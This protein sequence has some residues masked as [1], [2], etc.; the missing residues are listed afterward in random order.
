VTVPAKTTEITAITVTPTQ[1][2]LESTTNIKATITNNG[3]KIN[4]ARLK[5]K[6]AGPDRDFS[7]IMRTIDFI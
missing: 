1:P 2:D 7:E 6:R 3:G 4:S 5:F